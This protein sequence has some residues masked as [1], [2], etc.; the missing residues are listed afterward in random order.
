MYVHV[1]GTEIYG[2][3][4]KI[5]KKNVQI[6]YLKNG[7]PRI[8]RI[9]PQIVEETTKRP[10]VLKHLTMN[11]ARVGRVYFFNKGKKE[12]GTIKKINR[13]RP[14]VNIGYLEYSLPW[15]NLFKA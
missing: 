14:I 2:V 3:V 15:G 13:A 6:S 4:D 12:F 7:Q 10:K 5:L 8:V 9:R 1:K 11:K